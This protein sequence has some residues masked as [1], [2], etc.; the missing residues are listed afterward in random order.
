M[1][2]ILKSDLY[3]LLR[4]KSFWIYPGIC[5]LVSFIGIIQGVTSGVD[6]FQ[7]YFSIL[8]DD[9]SSHVVFLFAGIVLVLLY[10]EELKTGIV[11]YSYS[12]CGP[13][14]ILV[15]SRMLVAT[16]ITLFYTLVEVVL[17]L[18]RPVFL[19]L[20]AK[21]KYP[22]KS[23]GDYYCLRIFKADVYGVLIAFF[24]TVS[25]LMLVLAIYEI[26]FGR[27]LAVIFTLLLGTGFLEGMIVLGEMLLCIMT[28]YQGEF[29]IEH[30]MLF[31][32]Y[33]WGPNG[34]QT[35]RILVV[36]FVYL[37]GGA[38]VSIW[39]AETKDVNG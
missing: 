9:L 27:S 2:R 24:V 1:L 38:A 12:C 23:L 3:R 21:E 22:C 15:V 29:R 4:S 20:F 6:E 16:M 18:P 8:F 35:L 30:Y 32:D 11:K 36:A 10:G 33:E 13:R 5:V 28:N 19:Y 14:W 26:T 37:V 25:A 34:L 39:K 7:V 31:Q 17:K